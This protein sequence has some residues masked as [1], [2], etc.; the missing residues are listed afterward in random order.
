MKNYGGGDENHDH[1]L[2]LLSLYP[3]STLD[4]GNGYFGFWATFQYSNVLSYCIHCLGINGEMVEC[5]GS[6]ELTP[7]CF[8]FF[9]FKQ[10]ERVVSRSG[11]WLWYVLVLSRLTHQTCSMNQQ[12]TRDATN[13]ARG[14]LYAE[15]CDV[16]ERTC[17]NERH[18]YASFRLR[19]RIQWRF[20]TFITNWIIALRRGGCDVS[21]VPLVVRVWRVVV[22]KWPYQ[23][24]QSVAWL[25]K[26]QIYPLKPPNLKITVK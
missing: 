2:K 15:I 4:V 3:I 14:W 5:N 21:I 12:R 23:C 11:V 9:I 24:V 6:W 22:E 10:V 1:A 26:S 13:T 20:L 16:S 19:R 18:F 17:V 7:L 8:L 25:W